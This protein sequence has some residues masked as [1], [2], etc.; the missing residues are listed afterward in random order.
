M[1]ENE[2]SARGL[3]I[4][5]EGGDGAGKSTQVDLLK[6]WLEG[7]GR[8]VVVTR[9]PGGTDLGCE[10][11]KILLHGE[12]VSS[13]AEA[14]LYAADRAHHVDTLVRPALERGAVV[15]SDRY[16]DSSLAY[17]GAA[18]MLDPRQIYELSMWAVQGLLPRLTLLLDVPAE[19]GGARVGAVRDRLESAGMEFHRKVRSEFLALAKENPQRF[20][21]L[22][23]T[24]PIGEIASQI[25]AIA[26]PLL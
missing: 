3:F 2:T 10:I 23:G 13:R 16:L 9:E 5:F 18:R 24:L 12:D 4:S 14:L 26:E 21:V 19:K 7:C 11:R 15:I 6:T 20:R 1:A 17:Q 22:D 25:R 8:E